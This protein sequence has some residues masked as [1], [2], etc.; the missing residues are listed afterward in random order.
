MSAKSPDG[1]H[2]ADGGSTG[3][4]ETPKGGMAVNE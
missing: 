3:V 1:R 4:V 2:A